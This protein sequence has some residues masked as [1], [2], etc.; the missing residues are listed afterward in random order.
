MNAEDLGLGGVVEVGAGSPRLV[1]CLTRS[2]VPS[3]LAYS[4]MLRLLDDM[5]TTVRCSSLV[6]QLS[7]AAGVRV[8]RTW[9][10]AARAGC[11]GPV[12][13]ETNA[14]KAAG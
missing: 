12:V 14:A 7:R 4:E 11:L 6:A 10:G 9:W 8:L 5:N 1:Q 2:P 13:R 3:D